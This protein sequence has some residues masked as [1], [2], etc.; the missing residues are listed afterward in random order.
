MGKRPKEV[1]DPKELDRLREQMQQKKA[2]MEAIRIAYLRRTLFRA[3]IPDYEQVRQAAE[4]F[5]RA[6]Y[7]Y[8]RALYGKIKVKLS[9]ANLLR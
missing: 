1:Q 4:D 8:Q 7:Q 2:V 6:N 9:A 3:G 5:I